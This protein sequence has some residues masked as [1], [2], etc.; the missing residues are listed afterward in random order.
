VA[1]FQSLKQTLCFTPTLGYTQPGEKFIVDTDVSNVG[2]GVLLQVHYRQELLCTEH[3]ALTWFMG[4]KNLE[5]QMAC[6]IQHFQEKNFTSDHAERSVL[7]IKK[8][9]CRLLQP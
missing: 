9:R 1:T 2:I 3:S 7:T 6:W 5:G 4:F 8:L